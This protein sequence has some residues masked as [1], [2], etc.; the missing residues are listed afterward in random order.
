[1]NTIYPPDAYNKELCLKVSMPMWLVI[2]YL[3][4]PYVIL[5]VSLVDIRSRGELFSMVYGDYELLPIVAALAG[6]PALAVVYAWTRR[7]ANASARVRRIWS[8]GRQ[9]LIG[10]A[11]LNIIGQVIP[12]IVGISWGIGDLA[13]VQIAASAA[14]ICYLLVSRRARDTFSDFPGK[15]ENSRQSAGSDG[16]N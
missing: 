3:V 2:L 9:F 7:S 11:A 16:I 10:S 1:M 15:S 5:I 13:W 6:L 14:A 4:R 12:V 8:C